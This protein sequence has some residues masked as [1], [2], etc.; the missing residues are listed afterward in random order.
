M[1]VDDLAE[2]VARVWDAGGTIVIERTSI[3]GVG[4]LAQAID[5]N[6]VLFGMLEPV[7]GDVA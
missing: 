7:S 6:G 1:E 2:A 5:P 3:Q 4:D